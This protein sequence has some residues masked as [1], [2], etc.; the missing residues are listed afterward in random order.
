MNQ[1]QLHAAVCVDER[2]AQRF[3]LSLMDETSYDANIPDVQIR[4]SF[5][6][7]YVRMARR[8][9]MN[10]EVCTM[11]LGTNAVDQLCGLLRWQAINTIADFNKSHHVHFDPLK[12]LLSPT[13]NGS[14]SPCAIVPAGLLCVQADV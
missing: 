3:A 1:P 12:S 14:E 9:S 7:E 10:N 11:H 5:A 6:E 4:I 2:R 13:G 8:V